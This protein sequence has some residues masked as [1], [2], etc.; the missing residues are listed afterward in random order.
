M[1]TPGTLAEKCLRKQDRYL[2]KKK[3]TSVGGRKRKMVSALLQMYCSLMNG[4]IS[5]TSER[6]ELHQVRVLMRINIQ[7][8]APH[9]QLLDQN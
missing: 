7:S 5:S 1:T 4:Y 8:C 2:C 3:L 6:F 9:S